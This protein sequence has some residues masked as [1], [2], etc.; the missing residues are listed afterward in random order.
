MNTCKECKFWGAHFEGVCDGE[1]GNIK[2]IPGTFYDSEKYTIDKPDGFGVHA[3]ASD[4]TGLYSALV[5][6]PDFGCNRF[7]PKEIK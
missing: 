3:D 7:Q 1:I 6:G 2:R 4:D 5:T